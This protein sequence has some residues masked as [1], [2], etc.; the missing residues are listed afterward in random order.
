MS[1]AAIEALE[2]G[3]CLARGEEDLARR[4]FAAARRIIDVPW[5]MAVGADLAHPGVKGPRPAKTRLIN[6]YVRNLF[7]AGHADERVARAFLEVANLLQPPPSLFRPATIWRVARA[8]R[9][10]APR[11][12]AQAPSYPA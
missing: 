10:V 1:V 6:W 3:A 8:R 9:G 5:D 12:A 2:L 11:L 7:R 4:F